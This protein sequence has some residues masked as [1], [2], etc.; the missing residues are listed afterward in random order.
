[1]K[2]P[3]ITV[4]NTCDFIK[5]LGVFGNF[6][7]SCDYAR[8]FLCK[9]GKKKKGISGAKYYDVALKIQTTGNKKNIACIFLLF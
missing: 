1:M 8:L 5:C 7:E 3:V 4:A 9:G 2:W 6:W